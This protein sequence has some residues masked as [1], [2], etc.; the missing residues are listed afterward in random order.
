VRSEAIRNLLE[1]ANT[2]TTGDKKTVLKRHSVAARVCM[3]A[4][5]ADD[6][7]EWL[8]AVESECGLSVS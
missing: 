8:Y 4:P 2:R 6:D 5:S 7:V 3:A 1:N